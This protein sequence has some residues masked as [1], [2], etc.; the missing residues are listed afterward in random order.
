MDSAFPCIAE[1][2]SA[3]CEIM[4]LAS[5]VGVIM[6]GIIICKFLH[7][8]Y[9]LYV[10]WMDTPILE[11]SKVK[12]GVKPYQQ[13]RFRE[14][15]FDGRYQFVGVWGIRY[16]IR[17]NAVNLFG[18]RPCAVIVRVDKCIQQDVAVFTDN[19]DL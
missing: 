1:I 14:N 4:I 2:I 7:Y 11:E 6:H 18:V 12:I 17:R 3:K 10:E 19:A 8:I 15:C 5:V 16:H 13:R 9:N